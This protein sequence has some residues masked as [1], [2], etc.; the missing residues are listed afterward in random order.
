MT[1][2]SSC[3]YIPQIQKELQMAKI[4][5][6]GAMP[7]EIPKIEGLDVAAYFHSA[8]F[9]GGDFIR[10]LPGEHK[11]RLGLLIGDVCGK[12]IP[13]ALIMAVVYCL[14]KEKASLEMDPAELLTSVNLS[15]KE[16][17]G[18][19]SHFNSTAIWGVINLTEMEFSY[20]NAGHDFPLHYSVKQ[21]TEAIEL[22][23][24]G[25]LLG[26]FRESPYKTNKV[27]IHHGDRLYFYSDGLIDFFEAYEQ[28]EDGYISLKQYFDKS[29]AKSPTAIV[30]EIAALVKNNEKFATDDITL[31][32]VQIK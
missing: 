29:M 20:A 24:T 7:R 19:G 15:L 3:T 22:P 25:T 9:I 27:K 12:G 16:F 21:P 28:S 2:S 1:E 23:S 14:F 8:R 4:V 26:I 17:L 30:K 13:A 32:I 11:K 6:D 18:A 5:Q 31:T 10:F